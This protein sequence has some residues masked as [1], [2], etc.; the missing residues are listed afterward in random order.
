MA[1]EEESKVGR[2]KIPRYQIG[3]KG[4]PLNCPK[5][6]KK[7]TKKWVHGQTQ[8]QKGPAGGNF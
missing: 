6:G 4:A 3:K 2:G 7:E 8:G 1:K 5:K